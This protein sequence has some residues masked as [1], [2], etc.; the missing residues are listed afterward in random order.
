[1]LDFKRVTASAVA[2]ITL[3]LPAS[4]VAQY[5]DLRGE[6]ARDAARQSELRGQPRWDMRNADRRTDTGVRVP[7]VQP[8]A[9]EIRLVEIES[10]GFDW[11]D[12]GI[13][14]AGGLAIVMLA[15]GGV[16]AIATHRRRSAATS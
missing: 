9:P 3:A 6:H 15:G 14:A 7:P 12:A 16:A 11:G 5:Q 8:P 13:G 1:M 2:A 10:H 4:A